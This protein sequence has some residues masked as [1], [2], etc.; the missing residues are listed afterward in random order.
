[1]RVCDED[2]LQRA[3]H[4]LSQAVKRV[5]LLFGYE[6][7]AFSSKVDAEL[8]LLSICAVHPMR[9][10]AV[11]RLLE[12]CGAGWDL[13]ERLVREQ[14]PIE[15]QDWGHRTYLRPVRTEAAHRSALLLADG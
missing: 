6:G 11:A 1:V 10:E 7:N 4:T 8:D 5:E 3:Y 14:Q 9:Q 15:A 12:G 13:I 2:T